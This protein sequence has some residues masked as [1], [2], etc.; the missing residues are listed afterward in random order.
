LSKHL[1]GEVTVST[2][3]AKAG[4]ITAD[5]KYIGDLSGC[6]ALSSR[7]KQGDEMLRVFGCRSRSISRRMAV[8]QAPVKGTVGEPLALR[9]DV[10]GLLR[11]TVSRLTPDG[12]VV[13]L[14]L[15]DQEAATLARRIDW[16]RRRHLQAVPE[17]RRAKRWLPRDSHSSLILGDKR[18]VDCFIIDVSTS[19]AAVSADAAPALG[20]LVVVGSV[21]GKVVRRLDYGF[22]VQ[23]LR[24]QEAQRIEVLL[25]PQGEHNRELLAEAL[26][27]AEA[28]VVAAADAGPPP[29]PESPAAPAGPPS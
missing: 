19:G 12:F 25:A 16:L 22:A 6:Y 3:T 26:A 20:E 10:L 21:F 15:R 24:L 8:L 11:A 27:H 14:V 1:L 17:M 18:Q 13:D 2:P 7:E 4:T 29:G 9:L 28:A 23:F 5:V